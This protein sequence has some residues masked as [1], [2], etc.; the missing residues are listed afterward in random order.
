MRP[1]FS[2]PHFGLQIPERYEWDLP[3]YWSYRRFF[4]CRV[5]FRFMLWQSR[6]KNN[7]RRDSPAGYLLF[8]KQEDSFFSCRAMSQ[9]GLKGFHFWIDFK[10]LIVTKFLIVAWLGQIKAQFASC[11]TRYFL[12][13]SVE[14][15][16][17][18]PPT[19]ATFQQLLSVR[20][21]IMGIPYLI[22]RCL[23]LQKSVIEKDKCFLFFVWFVLGFRIS[24]SSKL[25]VTF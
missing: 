4:F 6:E 5:V 8:P 12:L 9:L 2:V 16:L 1:I 23:I 10:R 21:G 14:V 15:T 19:V 7:L 24:F 18:A 13:I 17:R 20:D 11:S 22:V 25:C 3:F